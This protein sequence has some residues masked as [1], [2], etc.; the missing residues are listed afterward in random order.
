MELSRCLLPT[1]VA[2]VLTICVASSVDAL[3]SQKMQMLMRFVQPEG[4]CKFPSYY[5]PAVRITV[6]YNDTAT[7]AAMMAYPLINA[8]YPW[9]AT[10]TSRVSLPLP[11]PATL[12]VST[13]RAHRIVATSIEQPATEWLLLHLPI[14][15]DSQDAAGLHGQRHGDRERLHERRHVPIDLHRV[16]GHR[17]LRPVH[18]VESQ[19]VPGTAAVPGREHQVLGR[20]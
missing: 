10:S 13:T 2:L 3:P 16:L 7:M 11:V 8:C 5:G 6:P 12:V 19:H 14:G 1:I 9:N 17:V 15:V 20:R 4:S 18:V